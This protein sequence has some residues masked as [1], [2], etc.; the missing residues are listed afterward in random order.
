[1]TAARIR[2]TRRSCKLSCCPYGCQLCCSHRNPCDPHS[3]QVLSHTIALHSWNVS[4][5]S[6]LVFKS[7]CLSS[8]DTV[9]ALLIESTDSSSC[10]QAS[11][12]YSGVNTPITHAR[13]C[14]GHT[15]FI[16]W[17][18][19]FFLTKSKSEEGKK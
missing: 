18:T 2:I 5:V 16:L 1:M 4:N 13:V 9:F 10:S 17:F 11:W 7:W 8:Y 3:S 12:R 15:F 19:D 14:L 6:C